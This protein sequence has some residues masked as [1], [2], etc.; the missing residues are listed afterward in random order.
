MK[1]SG[2]HFY[3]F[4]G[5]LPGLIGKNGFVFSPSFPETDTTTSFNIDCGN[6]NHKKLF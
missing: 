6:N 5:H 1:P 3:P 4:P 2:P